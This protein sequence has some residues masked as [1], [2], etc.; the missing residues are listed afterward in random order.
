MT[1]ATAD[2]KAPPSVPPERRAVDDPVDLRDIAWAH[3]FQFASRLRRGAVTA[4][5]VIG[6][7][8]SGWHGLRDR[9]CERQR[10][11]RLAALQAALTAGAL[12]P[13][14]VLL[15]APTPP[16]A[17]GPVPRRQV[18]ALDDGA[19]VV[20]DGVIVAGGPICRR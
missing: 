15:P 12:L 16:G 5:I 14:G 2:A 18:L 19:A 17:T 20:V 11:E 13:E 4:I 10:D 9:V 7:V 8:W 1:R 3:R 6:G